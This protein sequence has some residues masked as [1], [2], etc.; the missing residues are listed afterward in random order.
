M[1]IRCGC[2][3]SAGASIAGRG[4]VAGAGD[5]G[6]QVGTGGG[7]HRGA[8]ARKSLVDRSPV[9]CLEG[10]GEGRLK[11]FK[12]LQNG[13]CLLFCLKLIS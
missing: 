10:A 12:R 4:A 9:L 13:S 8:A 7:R 6:C 5:A 3:A 11:L 1:E 2:C